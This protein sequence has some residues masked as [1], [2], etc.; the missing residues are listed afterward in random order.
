MLT[1]ISFFMYATLTIT[2]PAFDANAMIPVKFTCEGASVSPAL[3]IGKLPSQTKSLAIIVHDPDANRPG[4]FTHWVVFN[5]D[6]AAD[7]PEGFK[8]GVQAM[9]GAGKPGYMGP[10]PPSGTHHYHFMVYALDT[11]LRIGDDSRKADLEKAMEGHILA[12]G[13]LVGLY[14]KTK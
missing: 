6:P 9:N 4:G 5:I 7:I 2:S 14:K 13:E 1:I 12:Q 10:C 3:H 11:R 8:G